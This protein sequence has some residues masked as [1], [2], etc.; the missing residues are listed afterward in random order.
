MEINKQNENCSELKEEG[1]NNDESSFNGGGE[2]DHRLKPQD[3]SE[4][5]NKDCGDHNTI[6]GDGS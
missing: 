6:A 2:E 3:L 1:N 5:L 4:E